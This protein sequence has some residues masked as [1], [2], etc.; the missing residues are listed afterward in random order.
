MIILACMTCR[1]NSTMCS[2]KI[3]T[4]SK[5]KTDIQNCSGD[6]P[7]RLC[8][9]L[10]NPFCSIISIR[11]GSNCLWK[12]LSFPIIKMYGTT[13]CWITRAIFTCP[14]WKWVFKL[15][16]PLYRNPVFYD[17]RKRIVNYP[18]HVCMQ[19]VRIDWTTRS[20]QC[21]VWF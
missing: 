1:R 7:N 19:L 13:K 17:S 3:N 10:F 4:I 8:K 2:V 16:R 21:D 6:P 18:R 12:W 11:A 5:Q 9:C 14:K 15:D 20:F